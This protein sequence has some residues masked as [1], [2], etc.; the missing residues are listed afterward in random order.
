MRP[1]LAR[2]IPVPHHLDPTLTQPGPPPPCGWPAS[3]HWTTRRTATS[4]GQGR[5]SAH[6]RCGCPRAC[7][8]SRRS[9]HAPAWE[10]A[11]PVQLLA[12]SSPLPAQSSG[13]SLPS[14]PNRQGQTQTRGTGAQPLAGRG[15][16]AARVSGTNVCGLCSPA[17]A[18]QHPVELSQKGGSPCS[19]LRPAQLALAPAQTP[20]PA[21][22]GLG[23]TGSRNM[24]SP[25]R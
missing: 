11:A 8:R 24:H 16:K 4:A 22:W 1:G 10:E 20:C 3:R 21:G 23:P 7:S 15:Q 6:A 9:P 2:L 18:L 5:H 19:P 14:E 17:V 25:P 12:Q 13:P